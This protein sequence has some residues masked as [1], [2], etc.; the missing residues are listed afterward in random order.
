MAVRYCDIVVSEYFVVCFMRYL[1][2]S[3]RSKNASCH[4]HNPAFY[5]HKAGDPT[6]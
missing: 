2:S 3:R 1:Q 4:S 6:G 5:F